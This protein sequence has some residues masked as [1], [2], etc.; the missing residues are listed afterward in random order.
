MNVH[1]ARHG[2]PP[3]IS[4]PNPFVS[5]RFVPRES[6]TLALILTLT[7]ALTRNSNTNTPNPNI[8]TNPNP[9]S[10]YT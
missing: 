7:L 4:Y 9:N 3:Y 2:L 8:N 6:L 10:R 1:C 5:R